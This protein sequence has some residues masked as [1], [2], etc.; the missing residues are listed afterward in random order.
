MK[1]IKT[2]LTLC[3]IC[4]ALFLSAQPKPP[5]NGLQPTPIPGLVLLA[6][7]GAAVGAKALHNKKKEEDLD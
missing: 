1:N 5:G 3:F 2:L 6:A 7:A 4:S